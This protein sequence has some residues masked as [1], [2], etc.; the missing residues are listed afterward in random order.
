MRHLILLRHAKSDWFSGADTD[1]KRPISKRGQRDLPLVAAALRPFLTGKILCLVSSALRTRQTFD[2]GASHWPEM[3]SHYEDS[4]YEASPAEIKQLIER[5]AAGIDTI[6]VIGHNPGL[7]MLVH[8]LQPDSPLH[9]PT[10]CACVLQVNDGQ[11]LSGMP[12]VAF[13]TPKLLK[14]S[15][16]KNAQKEQ[17]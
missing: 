8:E 16:Y 13:L 9:M 17:E 4:L 12:L 11:L 1:F 7:S 3:T 2:L 5:K 14:E 10:S 15:G 6:I